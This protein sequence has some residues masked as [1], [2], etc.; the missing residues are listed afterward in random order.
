MPT[1]VSCDTASCFLCQACVLQ[2]QELTALKKQTFLFRKG[3]QLFKE[4][5]PATGM[6]FTL[7][8]A[9]KVHKQ[10]GDQKELII[11]F[12]AGKDIIGLRGF[13]DTVFRVSATA[14]EAT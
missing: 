5:D 14:L 7:S 2:W 10:W 13:G 1:T 12:A 11:R 6:F 8:G 3:E 9:V 4:G